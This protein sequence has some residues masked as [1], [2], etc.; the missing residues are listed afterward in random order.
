[1]LH[2]I[3]GLLEGLP[4]EFHQLR[5]HGVHSRMYQCLICL[6]EIQMSGGVKEIAIAIIGSRLSLDKLRLPIGL[7]QSVGYLNM[8]LPPSDFCS[9]RH[10]RV[11]LFQASL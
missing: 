9:D 5:W 2:L 1:M 10:A 4:L 7:V 6:T 8:L 3:L 11:C